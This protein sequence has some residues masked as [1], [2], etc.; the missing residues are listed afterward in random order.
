MHESKNGVKEN[1]ITETKLSQ[2][3]KGERTWERDCSLLG[4]HNLHRIDLL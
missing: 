2:S 1:T 3:A 4:V